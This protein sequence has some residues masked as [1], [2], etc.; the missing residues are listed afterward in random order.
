MTKPGGD[1]VASRPMSG[2]Q[3]AAIPTVPAGKPVVPI[4]VRLPSTAT[5]KVTYGGRR[6]VGPGT[7]R[8]RMDER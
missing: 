5:R 4:D 8:V 2:D 1:T 7:A 6:R 3:L